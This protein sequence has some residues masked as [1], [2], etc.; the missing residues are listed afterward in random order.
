MVITTTSNILEMQIKWHDHM[1]P[2]PSASTKFV[3]KENNKKRFIM[4]KGNFEFQWIA[5]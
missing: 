1:Q 4:A 3:W 5:F 2:Q